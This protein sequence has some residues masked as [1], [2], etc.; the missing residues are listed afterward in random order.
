VPALAHADMEATVLESPRRWI[1]LAALLGATFIGTVNNSIISVAVPSIA[2]DLD[3]GLTQAVW[4][5]SAFALSLAVMMPLAGRLGD[6]VGPRRVFLAG[7]SLFALA[8][9][10]CALA[11]NIVVA[12]LG[13]ALQGAAGAPV[14]PCVMGTIARIFPREHRGRAVG[15]WAAVNSGALAL[16]PAAG[17][18]LVEL[19]GWRAIFWVSAPLIALVGLASA[20][21]VPPDHGAGSSRGIDPVGGVL[22]TASLVGLAAPITLV[23][24]YGV[25]HPSVLAVLGLFVV[26]AWAT[27]RHQVRVSDPFL[28]FGL[29][30]SRAFVEVTTIAALQMVALFGV[31]F[32]VPVFLQQYAGDSAGVAGMVTASLATTMFVGS[33]VSGRL[34][35]QRSF[36]SLALLGGLLMA[37]GLVLIALWPMQHAVVIAA[38]V[39][40]GAGIS[41]IQTPATVAITLS[42]PPSQTGVATGLFNTARFVAGGVGAT[43]TALVFERH[44]GAQSMSGVRWGLM[45]PLAAVVVL[46]LVAGRV[47]LQGHYSS[48]R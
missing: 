46:A 6:V 3:V 10:V 24:R 5:I 41:L 18:W 27:R 7:C 1:A 17:G 2:S 23:D 45:V 9:V 22:V 21:L 30:R 39:Y 4:M 33:T 14:L 42:V 44:G 11:D 8:S 34:A 31:T 26:S 36:A 12:V 43:L 37:G 19:A 29:V 28:D 47:R 16:G 32:V 35:E 40:C 13:R 38:L 25:T 20:V 48:T 15:M